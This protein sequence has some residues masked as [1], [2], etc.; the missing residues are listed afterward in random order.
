MNS[1]QF[2]KLI[3]FIFISSSVF[4]LALKTNSELFISLLL[5]L[6]TTPPY[7]IGLNTAVTLYLL[8]YIDTVSTS[9]TPFK[10]I[11]N[12]NRLEKFQKSLKELN[13]EAISNI[14]LAFLLFAFLKALE[15]SYFDNSSMLIINI[16]LSIRFSFV[17]LIIVISIMQINALRLAMNYRQIIE[18]KK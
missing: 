13:Q 9:I 18:N 10:T 3:L 12:A 4:Y 6:A 5:S 15:T 11:T 14:I 16:I 8:K 17:L 7:V 2:I 1:R